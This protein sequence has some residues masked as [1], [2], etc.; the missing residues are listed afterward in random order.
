M[1]FDLSNPQ[2]Q[3]ILGGIVRSLLVAA[4]GAGMMSGDQLGTVAGAIVALAGVAWSIYQK[5]NSSVTAHATLTTAVNAAASSPT[6]A[7]DIIAAAK[8]GKF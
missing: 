5:H 1:N 4:G 7:T 3:A 2:T 6:D 8:T